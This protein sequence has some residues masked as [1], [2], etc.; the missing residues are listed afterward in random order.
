[1]KR[2]VI[3]LTAVVVILLIVIILAGCGG[4]S[5]RSTPLQP[6]TVA[7]P[8]VL[9]S[10]EKSPSH[11]GA[12]ETYQF[13]A[14]VSNTTDTTVTWG[15]S[16]CTSACGS[17]STGGLYTAPPLIESAATVTITAT[18]RADPTKSASIN[19]L[20]KPVSVLLSPNTPANV[21][22][23]GTR[24]FT[25]TL[26][27]DPNNAGV[28]W[29]L[30][31]AGCSGDSCGTL[32][33]VT[34]TS[35]M[36]RA[37]D[38][39]PSP[40]TVTL[41]AT[42]I[43]DNNKSTFVSVTISANP[44]LLSG[45]YAFLING[46]RDGTLEAIGGQFNVDEN[47]NL[48]G[49][50]DANRGAAAELAQPIT[51]TYSI[52]LD[53]HGTMTFQAGSATSTYIVTVEADAATARFAE[54]TIP[55]G[56]ARGGS[57]GFMV[58]QDANYFT[59]SSIQGDRVIATYGEATGSHVAALGRFILNT[60]GA[61]GG[62]I[63]LSWEIH[64]NSAKFPNP[65]F[66]TGSFG[67]PD[68]STGRGTASL[69]VGSPTAGSVTYNFAYYIVSNERVLLVQ[70]DARGFNSGSLIPTLSGEVR[71][72]KNAGS[73]ANV[74][75]NLPLVFHLTDAAGGGFDNP[76]PMVRIGQIVPNGS[77]SLSATFD[78]NTG[79]TT[80]LNTPATSTYSVSGSGRVTWNAPGNAIAYLV[81]QNKG[82]FM[83]QDPDG[84]GFG[85]FEPQ[86][87][88]FSMYSL[89]GTFLLNTRHPATAEVENDVG[90]MTLANDATTAATL[91]INTGS[92]ASLFKF[93]GS[94]TV[95]SNGRGTLVLNTNPPSAPQEIVFWVIS[96]T[97]AV[98]IMTV[99][100][101]DT[102]PALLELQRIQ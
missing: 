97:R 79:G 85:A 39:E 19:V 15:V 75:L 8:A 3:L 32:N 25:A 11:L 38:V 64:Q 33:S 61:A 73:F 16:G 30:S 22:P 98:A 54:S 7:S 55:P 62:S 10:I 63:D 74:S 87:G 40:R 47:G 94:A 66:L 44:F 46:Y 21:V 58:R 49:I 37:P 76:V 52:Q 24:G 29:K 14:T 72:Q 13:T 5:T 50:W 69:Q 100:S 2:R 23:G 71:Y 59:L 56:A 35:V 9:V 12:S 84:A 70:T 68:A 48:T 53:G 41:T 43:T 86:S 82:Y 96:P 67:A 26:D 20:L 77:G 4:R 88:D 27:H 34:A 92:G 31:G 102:V 90:W 51:G 1:M 42:S 36:Y 95:S 91:Y 6:N 18:S 101:G 57:S 60:G 80:K 45:K 81:D 28:T 17:I 83:T 65:L 78:E 99:S 93:T 89:A